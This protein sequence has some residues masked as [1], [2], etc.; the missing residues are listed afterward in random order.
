MAG[1]ASRLGWATLYARGLKTS[2]SGNAMAYGYSV[3]ITVALAATTTLVER[4]TVPDLF[5]SREGRP[6]RLRRSSWPRR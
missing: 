3:A 1:P 6:L 5:L 4:P 2:I